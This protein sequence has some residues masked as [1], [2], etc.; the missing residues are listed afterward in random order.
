MLPFIDSRLTGSFS[1]FVYFE[2]SLCFVL[3]AYSF[4]TLFYFIIFVAEL[5]RS[6]IK[7]LFFVF[8][9]Y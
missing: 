4:A 6:R 5:R 7:F 2:V 8:V 1:A 9:F 3:F